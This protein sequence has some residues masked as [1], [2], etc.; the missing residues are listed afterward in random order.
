M[1]YTFLKN[2]TNTPMDVVNLIGSFCGVRHEWVKDNK[3]T[4]KS[5]I[6]DAVHDVFELGCSSLPIAYM[7]PRAVEQ[8]LGFFR[9]HNIN[10]QDSLKK[11]DNKHFDRELARSSYGLSDDIAIDIDDD[12]MELFHLF[13]YFEQRHPSYEKSIKLISGRYNDED[14]E[15]DEE[16]LENI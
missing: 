4:L 16:L 5:I 8:E 10:F 9:F 15:E 14:S 3:D 6:Q 1:A 7:L 11:I 2:E 13:E 12:F